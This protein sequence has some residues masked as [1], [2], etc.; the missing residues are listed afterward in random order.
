MCNVANQVLVEDQIAAH[1]A[2]DEVFTG[3]QVAC[4]AS[5]KGADEPNWHLKNHVIR[6]WDTL[7]APHGYLRTASLNV[8]QPSGKPNPWI[9]Y[10]ASVD[11]AVYADDCIAKA[12]G[13]T[14]PT[15]VGSVPSPNLDV[16]DDG[17]DDDGDGSIPSPNDGGTATK[18]ATG[19]ALTAKQRLQISPDVA[20]SVGLNPGDPAMIDVDGSNLKIAATLTNVS[21]SATMLY[22]N[23]DGRIRLNQKEL[24]LAG[25]GG[26]T[27]LE[28]KVDGT[29]IVVSN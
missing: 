13:K 4:E 6:N 16:D 17:D 27:H 19:Q 2:A 21:P 9:F 28:V 22:V 23:A 3:Y 1:I 5:A 20:E 8:G 15:T 25:L 11:P 29:T 24:A 14:A 12:G 10:P 7:I 18:V 26:K